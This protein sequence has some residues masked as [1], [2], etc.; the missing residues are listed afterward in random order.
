MSTDYERRSVSLVPGAVVKP[1]ARAALLAALTGATALF[2]IPI[3][4]SP[5]PLTLQVLFVFLAGLYLGPIWGP[6]AMALYLAAGAAGA[7]VFAGGSAGFG[8]LVG[9]TAGFLWSY[10]I[11]A[12]VIG[13]IVHGR[14][15][16][17]RRGIDPEATGID[18]PGFFERS[19]V[20]NPAEVGTV[21]LVVA[22][23]IATVIIYAMG[24]TYGMWLLALSPTEA[25]ALYVAPFL[26][27]E[28]IKMVA[29]V[30]VV[31]SEIVDPT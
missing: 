28:L 13:A 24:A 14:A 5:A 4:I 27:G 8:A 11:A 12:F 9:D 29:A 21:R 22:L 6:T 30:A 1:F 16:I 3:P 20:R 19:Q 2:S 23:V 15:G 25:L 26:I 7:P 18:R 17:G 10:P 31:R